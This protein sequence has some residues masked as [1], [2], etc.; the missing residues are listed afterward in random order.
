[1]R[2]VAE[3]LIDQLAGGSP[4]TD[5][6][7]NVVQVAQIIIENYPLAADTIV[8]GWADRLN[9]DGWTF[10]V[11]YPSQ[12]PYSAG[13]Y[14]RVEGLSLSDDDLAA[15]ITLAEATWAAETLRRA[16]ER[17]EAIELAICR[18]EQ[19]EHRRQLQDEY[20]RLANSYGPDRPSSTEL[21]CLRIKAGL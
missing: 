4:R 9:D 15:A 1:M 18:Q 12:K 3:I 13:S 10:E 16:D 5:Q 14:T 17:R 19:A 21:A 8:D 11:N 7:A 2:S 6:E 20:W